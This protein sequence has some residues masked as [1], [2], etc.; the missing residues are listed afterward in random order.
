[1][2]NKRLEPIR[3]YTRGSAYCSPKDKT[4]EHQPT[5]ETER[6]ILRPFSISDADVVM[7]LAG[8]KQVY[9]TTLNVP[10]PYEPGMAEK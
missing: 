8:T 2:A 7:A 1:M 5:I 3:E 9:A 10:Y 4:M 6:L